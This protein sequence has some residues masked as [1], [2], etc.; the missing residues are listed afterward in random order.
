MAHMLNP[1]IF[2]KLLSI[3]KEIKFCLYVLRKIGYVLRCCRELQ[4]E[5]FFLDQRWLRAGVGGKTKTCC[6]QCPRWTRGAIN[7]QK[8]EWLL[9]RETNRFP[10]QQTVILDFLP[11]ACFLQR[12]REIEADLLVIGWFLPSWAACSSCL[13]W[14]RSTFVVPLPRGF[15]SPFVPT[16][17]APGT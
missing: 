12:E 1:G 9:L 11:Y 8:K 17:S 4:R 6:P 16:L 3:R 14:I 15:E 7:K 13:T 10:G 2:F 5:I